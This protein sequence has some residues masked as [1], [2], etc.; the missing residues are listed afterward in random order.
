M[1]TRIHLITRGDDLGTNHS[2]NAAIREAYETGILR[3]A[4]LMAGCPAAEEAA[5]LLAG[6]RGLC[7]GLH[8]TLNAEAS[9]TSGSLSSRASMRTSRD[10]LLNMNSSSETAVNLTSW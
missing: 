3:N 2:A 8:S 9:R 10:C 1:P 7:V 5:E 4:S 6:E